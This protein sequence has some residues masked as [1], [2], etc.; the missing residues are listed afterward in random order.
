MNIIICIKNKN[1]LK[2]KI[3]GHFKATI[4]KICYFMHV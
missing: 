4:T 2:L 1:A 3:R